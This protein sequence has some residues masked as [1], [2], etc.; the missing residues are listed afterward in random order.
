M[1]TSIGPRGRE[2]S[3]RMPTGIAFVVGTAG[4]VVTLWLA[5]MAL[6]SESVPIVGSARGALL[7]M[8]VVGMTACAIGGIGQAPIIGWAHPITIIGIIFGVVALAIIGAGLF[9]WDGLVRPAAGIVPLGATVA[10]T[11][12]RL[13]IALLAAI[14]AGKWV[15]GIALAVLTSRA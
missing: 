5:Y 7:A 4:V 1:A 12:E 13:A 11:T 3:F 8:A 10:A 2:G 9:G 15:V 6:T 14:I